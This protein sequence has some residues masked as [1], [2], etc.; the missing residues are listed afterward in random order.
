[1]RSSLSS[2]A[3]SS[4]CIY[5]IT[6]WRPTFA[7]GP[8]NEDGAETVRVGQGRRHASRHP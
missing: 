6:G 4:A 5:A 3:T 8:T 7:A 2:S 1:M